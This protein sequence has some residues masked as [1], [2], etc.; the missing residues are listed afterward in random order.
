MKNLEREN[1]RLKNVMNT[2]DDSTALKAELEQSKTVSILTFI[3]FNIVFIIF[4][5]QQVMQK[6]IDSLKS[7]LASAKLS[8]LQEEKIETSNSN[9]ELESLQQQINIFKKENSELQS[10]IKILEQE[11]N[12]L[13]E[14]STI[15]EAELQ[16]IIKETKEKLNEV[17]SQITNQTDSTNENDDSSKLHELNKKYEEL[18]KTHN[19]TLENLNNVKNQL[20]TSEIE[21]EELAKA[22]EAM[23]TPSTSTV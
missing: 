16:L 4:Q 8:K 22:L 15:K 17:Q 9:E 10:N 2:A 19:E 11:K 20:E 5:A 18:S 3:Y 14:S 12:N 21:N 1:Q 6:T 7:E 23:D 13:I